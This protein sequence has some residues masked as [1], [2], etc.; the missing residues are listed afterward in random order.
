[1]DAE[2]SDAHLLERARAGDTEAYVALFGRHHPQALATATNLAGVDA[3]DDVIA[4]A[5]V[6]ILAHLDEGGGPRQTFT[7]Y[8]DLTLHRAAVD[9]LGRDHGA[10][11]AAAI[12]EVSVLQPSDPRAARTPELETFSRLTPQAQM[13]LWLRDVDEV[14]TAEIGELLAVDAAAVD[15]LARRAAAALRAAHPGPLVP[16]L[17]ALHEP[18]ATSPAG[19]LTLVAPLAEGAPQVGGAAAAGAVDGAGR[20]RRW[21]P[22][23]AAAA[24]VAIVGTFAVTTLG[25][26]PVDETTQHEAAF[27]PPT[28]GQEQPSRDFDLH[29]GRVAPAVL[30]GLVDARAEADEVDEAVVPVAETPELETMHVDSEN[31]ER[32]QGPAQT[33]ED[34]AETTPQPEGQAQPD[35]SA[36]DRTSTGEAPPTITISTIGVE[37][38][39]TRGGAVAR[40]AVA[41]LASGGEF[42]ITLTGERAQIQS[43]S[44]GGACD[45]EAKTATCSFAGG[46]ATQLAVTVIAPQGGSIGVRATRNDDASASAAAEV[47]KPVGE[48]ADDEG[49]PE[50]DPHGGPDDSSPGAASE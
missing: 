24:I 30:G 14:P 20:W 10:G 48:P 25:R 4:E 35:D 2:S 23:V 29:G 40:F 16:A 31:D 3:A 46:D 1:M 37:K 21:A 18:G 12:P 22:G 26:G 19:S 38:T 15:R 6:R 41:N 9:H 45:I 11:A 34:G 42:T 47:P 50:S 39:A 33:S 17:L 27:A 13:A 5:F 36:D 44:G 32:P 28:A 8:L 7:P 49:V 43:V